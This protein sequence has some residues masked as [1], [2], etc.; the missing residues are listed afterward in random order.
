MSTTTLAIPTITESD[1]HSFHAKHFPNSTKPTQFFITSTEQIPSTTNGPSNGDRDD[2]IEYDEEYEDLGTYPD[3][4]ARTLTDDQI[5]MF[6]H[7]EIQTLLRERRRAREDAESD[8]QVYSPPPI[9]STVNA[10]ESTSA[11]REAEVT[12]TSSP[13][14]EGGSVS[15]TPEIVLDNPAAKRKTHRGKKQKKKKK[16]RDRQWAQQQNVSNSTL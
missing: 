11:V 14:G 16:S 9:A 6:R 2:S 7:S 8:E 5:A 13:S 12:Q 1:L 3:G 10:D 4:T 15:V